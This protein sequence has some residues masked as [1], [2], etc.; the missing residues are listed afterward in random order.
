MLWTTTIHK[1]VAHVNILFI[2]IAINLLEVGPNYRVIIPRGAV[3]RL[4][5]KVAIML[6]LHE[7]LFLREILKATCREG[8]HLEQY[9]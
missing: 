5:V 2:F 7:Q 1:A 6:R 4:T 3:S 9:L 8:L